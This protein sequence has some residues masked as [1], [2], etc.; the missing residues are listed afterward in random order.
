M[1]AVKYRQQF[2][3]LSGL[4][5]FAQISACCKRQIL[6]CFGGWLF[7]DKC[8]CIGMWGLHV[9]FFKTG[10]NFRQYGD[11]RGLG[12]LYFP[13]R[14]LSREHIRLARQYCVPSVECIAWI[15]LISIGISCTWTYSNYYFHFRMTP[16]RKVYFS[17][18]DVIDPFD[19][20]TIWSL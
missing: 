6:E 10:V 2:L 12:G 13:F 11:V 20:T 4:C 15:G 1:L 16:A 7:R 17:V 14:M 5:L 9:W 18:H 3:I 8:K 19:S